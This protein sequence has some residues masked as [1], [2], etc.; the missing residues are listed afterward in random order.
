[1]RT[2]VYYAKIPRFAVLRPKIGLVEV[3]ATKCQEGQGVRICRPDAIETHPVKHPCLDMFIGGG[4][5]ASMDCIR[6]ANTQ[7]EDLDNFA[8]LDTPAGTL[9]RTAEATGGRV[10]RPTA[11]T[12]RYCWERMKPSQGGVYFVDF[13]KFK[14][15]V[16]NS[17]HHFT[18][19]GSDLHVT[20]VVKTP[21]SIYMPRP[22]GFGIRITPQVD[23]GVSNFSAFTDRMR[24]TH[25]IL[26]L[27]PI[28]STSF[29]IAIVLIFAACAVL[30]IGVW[31]FRVGYCCCSQSR[32]RRPIDYAPIYEM[33]QKLEEQHI[34][35][36]TIMAERD[37]DYVSQ[38]E[39]KLI[40]EDYEQKLAKVI[41]TVRFEVDN[42][43][44]RMAEVYHTFNEVNYINWHARV[45]ARVLSDNEIEGHVPP[46]VTK[47]LTEL[48]MPAGVGN[49]ILSGNAT[50]RMPA[51]T[52]SSSSGEKPGSSRTSKPEESD[53]HP[54][55]NHRTKKQLSE[56]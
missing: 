7:T 49:Q 46:G 55:G 34:R 25:P 28:K 4:M 9:V 30:I 36:R 10:S 33:E 50:I 19:Q 42:I 14:S 16:V 3:D 13:A 54:K 48:T 6:T 2:N 44:N 41:R 11:K 35:M 5:T 43:K 15:F 53:L 17:T 52:A 56:Y 12:S 40:Q 27:T 18:T 24:E 39:A 1:M 31:M 22:M 21:R 8:V 29:V 38:E 26:R 47:F 45:A 23:L 37:L 51:I 32:R 20:T